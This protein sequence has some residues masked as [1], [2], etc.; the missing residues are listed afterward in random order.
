MYWRP[1]ESRRLRGAGCGWSKRISNCGCKCDRKGTWLV[2]DRS[3]NSV[4]KNIHRLAQLL[5]L[6]FLWLQKN[7]QTKKAH[8]GLLVQEADLVLNPLSAVM[9]Q[10]TAEVRLY[11]AGHL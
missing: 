5:Q 11:R 4:L 10:L 2:L 7:K 8:R 6:E 1:A 3:K 9:S